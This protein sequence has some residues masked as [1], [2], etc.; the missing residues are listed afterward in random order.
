M[1]LINAFCLHYWEKPFWLDR[2]NN[3]CLAGK[4][5]KCSKPF[6]LMI[7]TIMLSGLQQTM[8][9]HRK[10]HDN[11]N[12]KV[13]YLWESLMEKIKKSERWKLLQICREFAVLTPPQANRS[14]W[15]SM[16][17]LIVIAKRLI[18]LTTVV[19]KKGLA[20]VWGGLKG[21]FLVQL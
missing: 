5:N 2:Y 10:V 12:V 4:V 19:G 1:P 14:P 20:S 6:L 9:D 17:V 7:I 3:A 18:F 21:C 15:H 16:D 8:Q 11:F 13:F